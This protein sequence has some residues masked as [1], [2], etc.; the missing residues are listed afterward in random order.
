MALDNLGKLIRSISNLDT[1]LRAV[2]NAEPR[3]PDWTAP[4]LINSWADTGGAYA[5]AAYYRD[6]MGVVHLRGRVT[7]GAFPSDAFVLP[8]NFRPTAT[9]SFNVPTGAVVDV[10][11]DGSVRAITGASYIALDGISFRTS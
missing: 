5:T 8:V 3:Q 4:T 6:Q 11:A 7:G 1:R 10:E 2:E 9:I